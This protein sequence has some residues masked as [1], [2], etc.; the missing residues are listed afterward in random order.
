MG[1][2]PHRTRISHS[3]SRASLPHGCHLC[4]W[5][6]LC[7]R[8]PNDK[9]LQPAGIP[10]RVATWH[11]VGSAGFFAWPFAHSSCGGCTNRRSRLVSLCVRRLLACRQP[12]GWCTSSGRICAESAY[13]R[14]ATS[15]MGPA[16]RPTSDSWRLC[17]LHWTFFHHAGGRSGCTAIRDGNEPPLL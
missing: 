10:T 17:C 15:R 1:L 16:V 3:T 6:H 4:R 5:L 9:R 7:G 13:T 11:E 12:A 2:R 14:M 8:W